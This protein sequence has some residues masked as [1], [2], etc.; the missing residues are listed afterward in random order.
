M[1][2][3]PCRF[4]SKVYTKDDIQLGKKIATGGFGAVFL[5]DLQQEDGSLL[6]VVVKKA[7]DF[8]PAE[9]SSGGCILT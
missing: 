4:R 1:V 5:A 2:F 8:G 6:P 9:V 3:P 7:T